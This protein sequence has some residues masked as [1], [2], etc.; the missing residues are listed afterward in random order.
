MAAGAGP[1][2][3]AYAAAMLDHPLPWTKMRQVYALLGL[4]K[5]VGAGPGRRRLRPGARRRGGQ[6][7]R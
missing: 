2:I 4:V 7:Q 6:R 1:A 3:G 5:Q